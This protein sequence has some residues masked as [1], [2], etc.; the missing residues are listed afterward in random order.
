VLRLLVRAARLLLGA[1]APGTCFE[2]NTLETIALVRRMH[3]SYEAANSRKLGFSETG[4]PKN[5]V[6]AT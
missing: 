1:T 4:L 6:S 2:L 5:L 3:I